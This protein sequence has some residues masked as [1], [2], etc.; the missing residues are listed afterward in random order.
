MLYSLLDAKICSYTSPIL[1]FFDP[2]K[3]YIVYTDAS[4][5]HV[6][7]NYHMNMMEQYFQ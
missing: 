1:C 4:D 3:Q 5:K 2:A 6:E 7:H